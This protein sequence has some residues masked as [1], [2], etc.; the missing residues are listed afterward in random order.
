MTSSTGKCCKIKARIYHSQHELISFDHKSWCCSPYH[1]VVV[2]L[3]S[4]TRKDSKSWFVYGQLQE[5]SVAVHHA[6]YRSTNKWTWRRGRCYAARGVIGLLSC[7]P[8]VDIATISNSVAT[9]RTL[10]EGWKRNSELSIHQDVLLHRQS[11]LSLSHASEHTSTN[12]NID[13]GRYKNDTI[14]GCFNSAE[15]S[16]CNLT[17]KSRH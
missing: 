6:R 5:S 10:C 9:T 17:C 7:S 13:R 12:Y 1:N 8:S 2:A 14:N 11:W 15:G 16:S 4:A 3:V